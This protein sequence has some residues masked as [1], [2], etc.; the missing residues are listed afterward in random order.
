MDDE[1]LCYRLL[2]RLRLTD[3]GGSCSGSSGDANSA[4]AMSYTAAVMDD[5]PSPCFRNECHSPVV[6]AQDVVQLEQTVAATGGMTCFCVADV[7]HC[8]HG[9]AGCCPQCAGRFVQNVPRPVF[10]AFCRAY[11]GIPSP[12]GSSGTQRCTMSSS[13]TARPSSM[14]PPAAWQAVELSFPAFAA[15]A[16]GLAPGPGERLLHLGSGAGQAVLA[17]ALLFP[18]G[19]A[20]GVEGSL[21]VHRAAKRA[22]ARLGPD[23]QR[24]VHF[25]HCDPFGVQGDWDQASVVLVSAA[26]FD[27]AAMARA[28][29]GLRCVRPGARVVTLSRPLRA[30]VPG[31]DLP[32]FEFLRQAAYRTTGSGNSSAWIYRRFPDS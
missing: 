15:L 1:E 2:K 8:D 9:S 22:A 4:A 3:G 30:A 28:L 24:R 6:V 18:Q 11:A 10:S 21:A 16:A 27:D 19:A 23:V 7:V 29:E 25:H 12:R 17:W 26:G 13:S 32:G 31:C 5:G 14:S 20:S